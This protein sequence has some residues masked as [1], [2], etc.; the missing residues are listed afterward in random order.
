[1]RWIWI[2]LMGGYVC[3]TCVFWVCQN[4]KSGA[5]KRGANC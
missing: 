5:E 1:M 4:R 3:V 2:A